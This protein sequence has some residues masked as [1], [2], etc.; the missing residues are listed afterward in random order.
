MVSCTLV[1]LTEAVIDM[2]D[3]SFVSIHTYINIPLKVFS[4]Q[5]LLGV[6]RTV[7]A[8]LHG[9]NDSHHITEGNRFFCLFV[10]F[11][12]FDK[13]LSRPWTCHSV[14]AQQRR[15][16]PSSSS[17]SSSL[18]T[19]ALFFQRSERTQAPIAPLSEVVVII[20]A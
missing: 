13:Q 18:L 14:N 15:P 3:L 19:P 11:V 10:F 8:R 4:H 16:S 17:P 6:S 1:S 20:Y 2:S 7:V 5:I 9:G 12:F